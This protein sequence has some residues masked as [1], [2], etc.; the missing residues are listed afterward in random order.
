MITN[1]DIFQSKFSAE[2]LFNFN[3]W[4]T[5]RLIIQIQPKADN[6]N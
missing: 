2:S 3:L 1:S 6:P 4:K 5:A